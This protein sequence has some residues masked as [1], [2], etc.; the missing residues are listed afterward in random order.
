MVEELQKGYCFVLFFFFF[1]IKFLLPL[2]LSAKLPGL[3]ALNFCFN[4]RK[5]QTMY[6]VV[7]ALWLL[8]FEF[9]LTKQ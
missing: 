7:V 3:G 9:S 5:L 2:T 6:F 1:P 8:V 4:G